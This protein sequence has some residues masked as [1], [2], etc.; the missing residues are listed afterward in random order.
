MTEETL[1]TTIELKVKIRFGRSPAERQT[2]DYPGCDA[3]N[4]VTDCELVD[5]EENRQALDEAVSDHL[6]QE[7]REHAMEQAEARV[8]RMR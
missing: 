1:E 3:E 8:G 4:E 7:R 6:E 2:W 5:C